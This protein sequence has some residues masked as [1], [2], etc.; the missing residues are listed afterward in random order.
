MSQT[1][2]RK[3]HSTSRISDDTTTDESETHSCPDCSGEMV[4][5]DGNT[6]E[7]ICDECGLIEEGGPNIDHGPEWRAYTAEGVEKKERTGSTSSP[8][9]EGDMTTTIGSPSKDGYGNTLSSSQQQKMRHLRKQNKKFNRDSASKRLSRGL[10]EVNRMGSALGIPKSSRETAAV[11]YRRASDEG[12]LVGYSIEAIASGALYAS[13]RIAGHPRS[14]DDISTVSRAGGGNE[15]YRA[16]ANLQRELN[17]EVEPSSP[18]QYLSRMRSELGIPRVYETE[19]RTLIDQI[20]PMELSGC[21]PT[22]SAA[23]ALYAAGLSHPKLPLLRQNR[24]SEVASCAPVSIRTNYI[25]YVAA[26]PRTSQ[27]PDEL[28]EPLADTRATDSE[29]STSTPYRVQMNIH[30]SLDISRYALDK[31]NGGV[32]ESLLTPDEK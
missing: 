10:A 4:P 21:D 12:I 15:V 13:L 7:L 18:E 22:V 28:T 20:D 17:L 3:R 8:L 31:P 26:S 29:S 30:G 32:P 16:Y 27:T 11:I 9:Y 24:L 2:Q 5:D 1:S 6:R 19:A 14:L 23:A 25:D